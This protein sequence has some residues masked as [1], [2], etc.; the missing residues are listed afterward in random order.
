MSLE[1]NDVKEGQE[2]F[3]TELDELRARTREDPLNEEIPDNSFMIHVL[4]SL[5]IEYESV[6]ESMEKDLEAEILKV[7][8]LKEQ[9]RSKY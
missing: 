4:N 7:E 5:T 6:V 2:I 9:V 3:I 1:L 8:L